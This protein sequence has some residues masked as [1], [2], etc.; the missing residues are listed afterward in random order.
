[1][2]YHVLYC[3]VFRKYCVPVL[4]PDILVSQ[5]QNFGVYTIGHVIEYPT[6][7]YFVVPRHTSSMLVVYKILIR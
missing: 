1:M 7:H 3:F 6:M 4:T 5:I 2:Q